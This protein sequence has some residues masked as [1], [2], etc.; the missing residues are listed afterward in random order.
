M[1][2][3]CLLARL[4]SVYIFAHSVVKDPEVA[5][6]T[7][8]GEDRVTGRCWCSGSEDH[9]ITKKDAVEVISAA[10]AAASPTAVA[11]GR[12]GPS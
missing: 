8:Q 12:W 6:A 5:M 11:G 4:A 10:T 1:T 7:Q 3:T 2:A 9:S